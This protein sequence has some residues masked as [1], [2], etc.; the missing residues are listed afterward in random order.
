MDIRQITDPNQVDA[1]QLAGLLSQLSQRPED[2]PFVAQ[3]IET[4]LRRKDTLLIVS[5]QGA[6]ITGTATGYVCPH[7][8]AEYSPFLL[9][10]ALVV[11]KAYRR[12]GI[13]RGLMH[14]MEQ[15]AAAHRCRY[16]TLASQQSRAGAHQF[17]TALGYDRDAAFQKFLM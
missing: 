13:G 10:E 12:Q 16:I 11:A 7:I 2:L 8:C 9:V 1:S 5:V 6:Q 15:C 14:W 17:Y 4:L 3:Q